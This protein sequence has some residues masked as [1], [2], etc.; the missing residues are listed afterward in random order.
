M[1][2]SLVFFNSYTLGFLAFSSSE[3]T[4]EPMN[5]LGNFRIPWKEYLPHRNSI[6]TQNKIKPQKPRRNM[7]T[8]SVIRI[9]DP[10]VGALKKD[11]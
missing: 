9:Q 1:K 7:F 6:R 11:L 3:L 4:S 2:Q 5:V 8:L 10:N